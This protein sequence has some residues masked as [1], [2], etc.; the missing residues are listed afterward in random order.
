M[1]EENSLTKLAR[2]PLHAFKGQ[3]ID[4]VLEEILGRLGC[5]RRNQPIFV[6]DSVKLNVISKLVTEH[7]MFVTTD[8]CKE[9]VLAVV[10]S[11]GRLA[12]KPHVVALEFVNNN[13]TEYT[14]HTADGEGLG[15]VPAIVSDGHIVFVRKDVA[16]TVGV[17]G[18]NL[19][20]FDIIFYDQ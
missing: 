16:Y 1:Q 15:Y 20:N 8:E 9:A 14:K 17:K 5:L 18:V 2:G 4:D 6:P 3:C 12:A 19:R 7:R 10:E 11:L 13:I